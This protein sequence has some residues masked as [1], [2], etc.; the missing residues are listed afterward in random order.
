M[1][2]GAKMEAAINFWDKRLVFYGLEVRNI[3]NFL[4]V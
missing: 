4:R 2:M 1:G 3:A